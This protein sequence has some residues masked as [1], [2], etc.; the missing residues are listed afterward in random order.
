MTTQVEIP[1]DIRAALRLP[2]DE[3]DRCLRVELA[4]ALYRREILGFGKAR[5]LA[6]LTSWEFDDLLGR[7]QVERH[8]SEQDLAED[9]EFA[10]GR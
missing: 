9:L 1:D 6:G 5:Q 4:V 3:V 7:R 10:A 2:P 8:Y